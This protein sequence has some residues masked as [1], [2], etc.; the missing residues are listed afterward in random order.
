M[1]QAELIKIA[2]EVGTRIHVVGNRAYLFYDE[3]LE[4]FAELVRADALDEAVNVALS[5][6]EGYQI[7]EDI[8]SLK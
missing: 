5:H 4:R 3:E 7:S 2:G 6:Y 1:N 8:R